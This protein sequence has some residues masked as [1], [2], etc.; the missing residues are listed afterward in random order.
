MVTW[1]FRSKHDPEGL[2]KCL[3]EK[4]GV[5]R[6]SEAKLNTA[7]TSFDAAGAKPVIFRSNYGNNG[8][9]YGDMGVVE[10]ALATSAAPTYFP[11]A[12]AAKTAMLD[13]GIWANCPALVA[14]T[15]AK[16]QFGHRPEDVR[17]LSIGTTHEPYYVTDELR[18]GGII[19]WAK[20]ISPMLMHASK[21]ATLSQVKDFAGYFLRIDESVTPGRFN[22]DDASA[23]HDLEALG[24][25]SARDCYSECKS[26]FFSR[27]A[28]NRPKT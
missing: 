7:V 25:S 8:G 10:V 14:L 9:G 5:N 17:I 27:L 20:P 24:R 18:E 16:T 2:R 21:T 19:D 15:E 26:K 28:K 3:E 1:I 4:F 23:I 12:E 11:A 6:L 22:M 13:G